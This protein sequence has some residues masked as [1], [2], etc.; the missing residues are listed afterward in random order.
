ME[1]VA[2]IRAEHESPYIST[3]PLHACSA[4]N[5]V[6]EEEAEEMEEEYASA[7]SKRRRPSRGRLSRG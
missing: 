6:E 5:D 4:T 2:D 1:C 3:P 7:G